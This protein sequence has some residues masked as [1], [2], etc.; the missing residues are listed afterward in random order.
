VPIRGAG[1][2]SG[3][4]NAYTVAAS[5]ATK[6]RSSAQLVRV[7]QYMTATLSSTLTCKAWDGSTGGILAMDVSARLTLNGT[8]SVSGRG[9]RGGIQQQLTGQTGVAAT[10]YRILGPAN[11]TTTTG[12]G[13]MKGEGI[14]GTPRLMP[15]ANNG[16]GLDGCL[17]GDWYRGG[18]G[19]AG[20]GGNDSTPTTNNENAG[21]GGGGNGG[22]GGIGGA[23]WQG[24][25]LIGGYPGAIVTATGGVAVLGGGGGAG[26]RN[27]VSS[28]GN[29]GGGAGG[30]IVL[31]RTLTVSGTGAITANGA[32]APGVTSPSM[33]DAAGGGGAGGTVLIYAKTGGLSGLSV[34]AQGG[35]GGDAWPA[36]APGI[37]PGQHHGPGG[38]GGG[39]SILLSSA[40]GIESVNG[41]MNGISCTDN[42]A[43]GS[44]PGNLGTVSTTLAEA[45]LPGADPGY[46]CATLRLISRNLSVGVNGPGQ[47]LTYTIE[48]TNTTTRRGPAWR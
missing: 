19:N 6:G 38:G 20:G 7:P 43:Y 35:R 11:G 22:A 39:G 13:G 32:D 24:N 30:G 28:G 23:S 41:G 48:V 27:N 47:T 40:P 10:D 42:D 3:T 18:P 31:I 36:Q 33:S 15:N 9:F 37:W 1:V 16:S 8:T 17:N 25:Q 21:G 26:A 12:T 14:A 4:L 29:G 2:G 5:S 46:L 34:T 44:F 45:S